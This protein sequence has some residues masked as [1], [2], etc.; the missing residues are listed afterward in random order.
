[1]I[2][3]HLAVLLWI[4]PTKAEVEIPE[5]FVDIKSIIPDIEVELRYYSSNNFVG[6]TIDGYE[7]N[8]CYITVDAAM[9]LREVQLKLSKSGKGLKIFDAY[10]P[11]Q[12]VD[13]FVRW[14]RDLEDQRM[15]EE[16]YPE[17][18]KNLL[19]Q[20]GYISKRSG[21]TR[22]STVDLTIV[23]MNDQSKTELDMGTPFDFF[24]TKSWTSSKE[25]TSQQQSNR[26]LL[27]TLMVEYGFRPYH[28]EWWHFTLND[29]PFP[30]TY[31]NFAIR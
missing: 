10:R 14:S 29:E 7:A 24:G 20:E 22:G 16:Y 12:A 26:M 30:D 8:I 21:H 1:M 23:H 13:H 25:V 2:S 15:K 28:A 17:V 11:Q 27:Q 5:H 9:A 18:E 4:L 19:F 6:D 31:F 3:I